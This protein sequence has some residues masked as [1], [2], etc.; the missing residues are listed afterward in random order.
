MVRVQRLHKCLQNL[1]NSPQAGRA[2]E[3]FS[4]MN[5]ADSQKYARVKAAVLKSYELVPEAYRRFLFLEI[6]SPA[7]ENTLLQ[8]TDEAGVHKYTTRG[9]VFLVVSSWSSVSIILSR[10]ITLEQD[11]LFSSESS[12]VASWNGAKMDRHPVILAYSS[13][14]RTGISLSKPLKAAPTGSLWSTSLWSIWKVLFHL[15]STSW[16]S[17]SVGFPICS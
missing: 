7:L 9:L 2:Q 14:V 17:F 1:Q 5:A 13:D 3:V 10:G 6:T 16:I 11:T 4:A 8:G 15:V 12:T